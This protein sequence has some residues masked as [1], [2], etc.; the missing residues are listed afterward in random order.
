MS[1]TTKVPLSSLKIGDLFAVEGIVTDFTGSGNWINISI[2]GGPV[3]FVHVKD[4]T[5]V[6]KLVPPPRELVKGERISSFSSSDYD[7]DHI[8]GEYLGRGW[9]WW[10]Q[11]GK[12][13]K[14][15]RSPTTKDYEV[16]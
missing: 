16:I 1:D 15:A 12:P 11:E 3:I 2:G 8:E 10:D 13:T 4:Q 5:R 7:G 6:T 9:V 14:L